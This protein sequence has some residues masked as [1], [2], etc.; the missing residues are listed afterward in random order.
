MHARWHMTLTWHLLKISFLTWHMWHLCKHKTIGVCDLKR[1]LMISVW[2]QSTAR[3]IRKQKDQS[4]LLW[5][6]RYFDVIH[7]SFCTALQVEHTQ[8]L[9]LST[10]CE[11]C[12]VDPSIDVPLSVTFRVLQKIQIIA[13]PLKVLFIKDSWKKCIKVSTKTLKSTNVFNIDK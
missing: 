5:L 6:S 9:R 2:H 13:V 8:R 4:A 3:A 7:W 1:R 12:P 11:K 10:E